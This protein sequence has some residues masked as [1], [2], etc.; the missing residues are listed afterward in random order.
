M[1]DPWGY[2]HA[3]M[4]Q[5][6]GPAV[7]LAPLAPS[8]EARIAPAPRSVA[9]AP[10][11]SLAPGPDLELYSAPPEAPPPPEEPE[12]QRSRRPLI[13]ALVG[14]TVVLAAGMGAA[15]TGEQRSSRSDGEVRRDRAGED[16][17]GG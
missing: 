16:S 10:E 5:T 2:T 6:L 8:E 15:G 3:P 7:N 9:A 12:E 13:F 4:S 11:M 17:V 1:F 14:V